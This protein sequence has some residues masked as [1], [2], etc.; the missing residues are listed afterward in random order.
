MYIWLSFSVPASVEQVENINV[1]EG[2][3]VHEYCNVTAGFPHPTVMWT[4][5]EHIKEN[6]LNITNINR[7]QAGEYRCTANN[8]CGEASTVMKISVQC[9]KAIRYF[10]KWDFSWKGLITRA[11]ELYSLQ[12]ECPSVECQGAVNDKLTLMGPF[13]T[14]CNNSLSLSTK[15]KIKLRTKVVSGLKPFRKRPLEYIFNT[16]EIYF[17]LIY[18]MLN[19]HRKIFFLLSP[20]LW[21]SLRPTFIWVYIEDLC[22]FVHIGD[23]MCASHVEYSYKKKE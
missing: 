17:T 18:I 14:T 15:K 1:T 7:T 9:K 20:P 22:I 12:N 19:P 23:N 2:K 5:D 13:L 4:N 3:N 16:A 6:P 10:F 21:F 11:E 8:T